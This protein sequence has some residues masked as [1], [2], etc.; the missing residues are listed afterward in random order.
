MHPTPLLPQRSARTSPH[1]VGNERK[2]QKPL[3]EKLGVFQKKWCNFCFF[4]VIL[5]KKGIPR[6]VRQIQ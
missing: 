2:K 5:G 4:L 1:F 3:T 6:N